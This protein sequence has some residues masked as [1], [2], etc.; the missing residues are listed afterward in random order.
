[1]SNDNLSMF[2][3]EIRYCEK[4]HDDPHWKRA[5]VAAYSLGA[6]VQAWEKEMEESFVVL[7][8]TRQGPI[9]VHVPFSD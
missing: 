6:A 8:I 9:K 1:M 3:Y 5:Y 4:P 7:S 2:F